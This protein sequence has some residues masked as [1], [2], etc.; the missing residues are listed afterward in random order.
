MDAQSILA[1]ID[2]EDRDQCDVALISALDRWRRQVEEAE[3]LRAVSESFI[4]QDRIKSY[5]ADIDKIEQDLVNKRELTENERWNL[6]DRRALYKAFIRSFDA[7]GLLEGIAREV[8]EN[9]GL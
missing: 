4:I 6:M 3:A 8:E 1:R 7:N 2:G 9:L 5:K